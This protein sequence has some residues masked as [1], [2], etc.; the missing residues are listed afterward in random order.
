MTCQTH[1]RYKFVTIVN[2][3]VRGAMFKHIVTNITS[4]QFDGRVDVPVRFSTTAAN[5]CHLTHI[6]DIDSLRYVTAV[7]N[8]FMHGQVGEMFE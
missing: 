3:F 4:K 6:T 1:H 2:V 5:K 7:K 8:V